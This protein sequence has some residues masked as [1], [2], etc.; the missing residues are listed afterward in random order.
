MHSRS[1]ANPDQKPWHKWVVAADFL[2]GEAVTGIDNFHQELN[3]E[4]KRLTLLP[5]P[6]NLIFQ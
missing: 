5:I 4:G 1:A 2:R 3:D 6:A